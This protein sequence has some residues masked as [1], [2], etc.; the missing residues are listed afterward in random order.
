M[1]NQKPPTPKKVDWNGSLA[2]FKEVIASHAPTA[3]VSSVKPGGTKVSTPNKGA[4]KGMFAGS[5][6]PLN[7]SLGMSNLS[8]GNIANTAFLVTLPPAAKGSA[9]AIAGTKLVGKVLGRYAVPA[10]EGAAE[11]TWGAA[12][13]G[14]EAISEGGKT[15]ISNTVFGKTLAST[16]IASKAET[17]ARLFG[18]EANAARITNQAASGAYAGTA[19]AIVRDLNTAKNV[20]KG[21]V[22]LGLAAKAIKKK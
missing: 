14:L 18:L 20:I 9:P 13:K 3:T 5:G 11:A 16:K 6:T 1:T 10:A 2:D 15:Y 12:T 21:A 7:S 22:G 17:A 4:D 19:G 8:K